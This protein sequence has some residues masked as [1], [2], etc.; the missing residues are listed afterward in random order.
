MATDKALNDNNKVQQDEIFMPEPTVDGVNDTENADSEKVGDHKVVGETFDGGKFDGEKFNAETQRRQSPE[1]AEPNR[2]RPV[3]D[4]SQAHVFEEQEAEQFRAQWRDLQ[5]GFV[6]EPKS[7]VRD[8]EALVSQMMEAL[9]AH[10]TEQRDALTGRDG[11]DT[12]ELRMT[13]RRYRSLAEKIL[14]V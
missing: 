5:A 11:E 9:T 8:A 4:D 10:I 14:S 13:M 12:E 3:E 6:D 2:P 1:F 7:A